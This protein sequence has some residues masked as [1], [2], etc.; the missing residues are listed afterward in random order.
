MELEKQEG[1]HLHKTQNLGLC[2]DPCPGLLPLGFG[3]SDDSGQLGSDAQ[4]A[5]EVPG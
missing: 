3:V 4:L 5:V 2:P 1:S